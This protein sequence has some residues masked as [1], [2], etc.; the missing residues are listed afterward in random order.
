MLAC[1]AILETAA[2]SG[3]W[4]FGGVENLTE[5]GEPWGGGSVALGKWSLI[6]LLQCVA[7]GESKGCNKPAAPWPN[8]GSS[9]FYAAPLSVSLG[10]HL[11]NSQCGMMAWPWWCGGVGGVVVLVVA[12]ES[13]PLEARGND[14]TRAGEGRPPTSATANL[15]IVMMLVLVGCF[16]P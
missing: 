4:I 13:C 11:E 8:W 6:N 16:M 3:V 12:A 9:Q 7:L 2:P 1:A 15:A 14:E 5:R 10:R